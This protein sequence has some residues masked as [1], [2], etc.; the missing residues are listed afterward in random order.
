MSN[1]P[2]GR[3]RPVYNINKLSQYKM[4]SIFGKALY[5]KLVLITFC[6]LVYLIRVRVPY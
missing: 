6:A 1:V 2:T 3:L 4:A 5:N